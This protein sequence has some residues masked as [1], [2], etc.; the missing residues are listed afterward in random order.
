M[1][2]KL[3][4]VVCKKNEVLAL[5]NPLF[6]GKHQQKKTMLDCEQLLDSIPKVENEPPEFSSEN[7]K[8]MANIFGTISTG[9]SRDNVELE[10]EFYGSSA[11]EEIDIDAAISSDSDDSLDDK[12]DAS[13]E[14]LEMPIK[15]AQ[16]QASKPKLDLE[17]FYNPQTCS[18]MMQHAVHQQDKDNAPFEPLTHPPKNV[19]MYFK[20]VGS[21]NDGNANNL[22]NSNKA[23]TGCQAKQKQPTS[24]NLMQG[25]SCYEE[26]FEKLQHHWRC[27]MHSS[28]GSDSPSQCYTPSGGY[29]EGKATV[30][31]KPATLY[32][33]QVRPQSQVTV[34]PMQKELQTA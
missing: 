11:E 26:T 34:P 33:H 20:D 4:K 3:V 7:V 16:N 10:N 24:S 25:T 27:K 2:S 23:G 22:S 8:H 32:L 13:S 29:M 19:L 21:G 6:T 28:W 12:L 14:E 30:D 18:F 5:P 31:V 15:A 17:N 1:L 9:I